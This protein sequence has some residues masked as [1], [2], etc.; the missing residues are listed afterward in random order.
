MTDEYREVRVAYQLSEAVLAVACQP[1]DTPPD[2]V[3]GLMAHFQRLF[4]AKFALRWDFLTDEDFTRAIQADPRPSRANRLLLSHL[5]RLAEAYQVL[6]VWRVVELAAPAVRA[7]NANE[8][9][10]AC[11]LSRALLEVTASFALAVPRVEK[12]FVAL[13][14]DRVDEA[15]L[16]AEEMEQ[17]L[18]RL[19]FGSRLGEGIDVLKQVNIITQLE[20]LDKYAER[21][22]HHPKLVQER[23]ATLSE[24]AHPNFLGF[25]RFT[26][27]MTKEAGDGW[28][29]RH[30]SF[31]AKGAASDHLVRTCVWALAFAHSIMIANV[32]RIDEAKKAYLSALGAPL[33]YREK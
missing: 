17:F 18:T 15:F 28:S 20:K 32:P 11:V 16:D 21:L 10:A 9:T 6:S 5:L 22:G 19:V 3:T 31:G 23:Y 2:Q 30:T 1:G 26:S 14:W 4:T 8:V 12:W 27:G 7:L 13:P 33:P 25:E 29:T 24:A